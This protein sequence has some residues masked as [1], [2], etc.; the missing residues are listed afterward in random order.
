MHSDP[1][2]LIIT[3]RLRPGLDGGY[4]VATMRRAQLLAEAG[5]PVVLA[6]VDLHPDYA[7]FADEF[8]GMGLADEKTVMRN[9]LEEVRSRPAILRDAADPE[10]APTIDESAG[11]HRE[12]FELDAAGVP[13]RQ[14]VRDAAGA[15]VFTDFFDAEGI[16]LFRLPF[17]AAPDWWRTEAIIDVLTVGHTPTGGAGVVPSRVGGLTG[18]GALYRAWW[19]AVVDDQRA[20]HPDARLVAIAEARQVGEHWQGTGG[21]PLVHTVHNAHTT[22]PHDWDSP[23]DVTWSGWFD[24][25]PQYDAVVW[26]T[27]RQRE[28]VARRREADATRTASAA[29]DAPGYVIPHPAEPP[30]DVV[31]DPSTVAGA[32]HRD[33]DRAVMV[34]RLAPQKRL[35]HA[36]R[37][38]RLV[39]DARPTA[40]L[41][42]YGDGPL[43]A[44]LDALIVELD[45]GDTVTLHG[46][47]PDAPEQSRTAALLLLTSVYEGQSLA[48]TEAMARGCPAVAY[49]I[50][51][52]PGELITDGET[53]RLVPAGDIAALADAVLGMLGNATEISRLSRASLDWAL[54]NGPE[55]ALA[56]W[57]RLFADLA[58]RTPRALSS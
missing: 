23:M 58:G 6:T 57:E 10:L 3:S 19:R 24:T 38:W 21:V 29:D 52:G 13:W 42:I 30:A 8:R 48:I 56:R 36:I 35:D 31:A 45:L 49:D 15:V 26:L 1:V 37:A 41:H 33:L 9:L 18:F 53:G 50:A 20:L 16:P 11:T 47:T 17:V 34:A 14:V 54:A 51:Y 32:A 28:E 43:R 55:R 40:R 5:H 27:E 46:H 25:L 22:P 2:C 12:A 4:T 7:P 44:D 39:V